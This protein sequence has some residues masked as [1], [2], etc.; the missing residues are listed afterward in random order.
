[1]QDSTFSRNY[2]RIFDLFFADN[3]LNLNAGKKLISKAFFNK[4]RDMNF[5]V[6]L[7]KNIPRVCTKTG[8]NVS[9]NHVYEIFNRYLLMN[10]FSVVR[11]SDDSYL[12]SVFHDSKDDLSSTRQFVRI[13]RSS[14]YSIEGKIIEQDDVRFIYRPSLNTLTKKIC[15]SN[16]ETYEFATFDESTYVDDLEN[17][18]CVIKSEE[19]GL[20][21][22]ENQC[23]ACPIEKNE[24]SSLKSTSLSTHKL[25]IVIICCVLLEMFMFGV[26]EILS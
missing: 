2:S 20:S 14:K 19:F 22:F 4:L 25:F 23:V 10:V 3:E 15:G 8:L 9:V 18:M 11:I 6:I 26:R 13:V 5:G 21:K 16:I 12:I 17:C 24:D 1:M 7:L